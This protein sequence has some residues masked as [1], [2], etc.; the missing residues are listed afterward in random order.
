IRAAGDANRLSLPAICICI[1]HFAMF[2]CVPGTLSCPEPPMNNL[3]T[4]ISQHLYQF[5]DTCNVYAVVDGE[6]ALLIDAGAG[7]ALDDLQEIGVRRVEWVLHTHHHRDQC[8]GTPR[9]AQHGARVAVPE[10][11][12]HL[13]DQAELFWQTRRTFD[14]YNDRNTFFTIGAN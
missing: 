6:A 3:W 1:L 14:N 8:W 13:F 7:P 12:R 5:T 10:Y 2:F 4:R 11:E 9:L